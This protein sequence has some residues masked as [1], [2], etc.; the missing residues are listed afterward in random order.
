MLMVQ[1]RRRALDIWPGFVDGLA[2]L[3]MV[4]IFVLLL[5]SVGQVFL[6]DALVGRDAALDRLRA[7]GTGDAG[8]LSLPNLSMQSD[9]R[10]GDLLVTSG[11]GERFPAGFKV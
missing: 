10:I 2:A 5:F 6:S 4:V 3:L 8:R 7:L 11:L 1:K 9:V